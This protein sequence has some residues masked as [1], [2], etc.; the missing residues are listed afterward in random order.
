MSATMNKISARLH[1][2]GAAGMVTGQKFYLEY[3]GQNQLI[4]CGLFQ[5]LK[6]LRRLNWEKPAFDPAAVHNVLITHAHLDHT[7]YLP[8]MVRHGFKGPILGT[9]PTLDVAEIILNDSARLQV[10]E[11]EL[12]NKEGFS[13]HHPALPLYDPDDVE[14]T[15]KLF[16]P[17]PK[18]EWIPL[19]DHMRVRFRY[20]GHILGATFIELEVDNKRI[21]ISGDIGR[22][23]DPLMFPPERPEKADILVMESTYGDRRHPVEDLPDLMTGIMEKVQEKNGILIIPSFAVERTQD[24]LFLLWQLRKQG[25]FPKLPVYLDTPMGADVTALFRHHI[26]WHRLSEEACSDMCLNVHI[27]RSFKETWELIDDPGSKII[28]AGSGMVTGGRVLT[29][30]KKYVNR[31]DTTVLL[32][33]YQAEGTRG[34]QLE[35]GVHEIRIHGKYYPVRAQIL[36]IKSLSAHADQHELLHWLGAL[37]HPPENVYLVHG[38]AQATDALRVKLYD[39]FGWNATIPHLNDS[40]AIS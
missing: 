13:I 26:P 2:Y 27:V 10:E 22:I 3:E 20:A 12:A 36:N 14:R 8:V 33:G 29:W 23:K 18:D 9:A 15:V 17:I 19:S 11:A 24:I 7:G 37:T 38:E 32:T 34:R 31:P 30:L 4:D 21:V 16:H 28:I 1:F 39:E 35:E 5:G 6:A 40:V 25:H